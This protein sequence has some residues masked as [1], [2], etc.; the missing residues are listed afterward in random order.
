MN[1][2][3][4]LQIQTIEL[5]RLLDESADNP[6]LAPQLEE[7]L[8][9]TRA[10]L[11]AERRQPGTI[12]PKEVPSLPRAAIFMRGEAVE[13]SL[14]IRPSLAAEA[15]TQFEKMFREQA[16]HDEREAAR[17]AGRQRRPRGA[18]SPGLWFTGTPRGSFGLEFVPQINEDDSLVAVHAESLEN[19]ATAISVVADSSAS[20]FD[21]AVKKIPPAVIPP[22][23]QFLKAL[24]LHGAELRLA[25][26]NRPSR[27]LSAS[28]IRAA[29][30]S[31]EKNVEQKTVTV[32]GTFRG[33]T[34]DSGYFD[35]RVSDTE[36]IKGSL[37]DSL[38]EDEMEKLVELINHE[39]TASLE[40][41]TVRKIGGGETATYVLL[42]ARRR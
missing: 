32:E 23:T 33:I 25:F 30:D 19:V 26:H 11:E 41:T 8:N 40:K 1:D 2:L 22:L 29:A 28:S 6:I 9:D 37:A 10:K 18:S 15:L 35:L 31:L 39:C 14:G 38:T 20:S 24:S 34:L 5:Q 27:S 16:V 4:F 7:R 21:D 42:T 12:L 17:T 36:T 13:G 3:T